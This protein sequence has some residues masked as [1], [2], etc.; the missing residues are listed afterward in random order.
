MAVPMTNEDL[1]PKTARPT[2]FVGLGSSHGDDQAGW[3]VADALIGAGPFAGALAGDLP[4]ITVRAARHPAQVLDWLEG[5]ERLFVCD[6]VSGAGLPGQIRTWRWPDPQIQFARSGG[7]HDLGLSAVLELAAQL[8]RLPREIVIW[9]IEISETAPGASG[10][11]PELK[12]ALP[13]A[14][15]QIAAALG[16]APAA[17]SP[18]FSAPQQSS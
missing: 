5:I 14:I 15:R 17:G 16:L 10:L 18:L 2:L 12:A 3:L 13:E 11:S 4:P 6:A 1:S 9:G 8:N 7:S